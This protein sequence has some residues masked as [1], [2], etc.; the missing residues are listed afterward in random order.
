MFVLYL[1]KIICDYVI[2][3]NG[4]FLRTRLEDLLV[5]EFYHYYHLIVTK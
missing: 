4:M 3:G 5:S 1:I 2:R